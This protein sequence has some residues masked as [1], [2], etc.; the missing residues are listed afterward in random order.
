V[1]YVIRWGDN[2]LDDHNHCSELPR[3]SRRPH[4][5]WVTVAFL[6]K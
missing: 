3:N 6:A 5:A 2:S 4:F 1:T